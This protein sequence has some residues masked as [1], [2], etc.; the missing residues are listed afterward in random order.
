[1][2]RLLVALLTAGVAVYALVD[3]VRARADQVQRLPRLIWALLVMTLPLFGGLAYLF[4]GR[5]DPDALQAPIG[6][7]GRLAPDDDPDFLATLDPH[8]PPGGT[9]DPSL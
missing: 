5:A 3:L 8:R 6:K 2:P 7:N 4:L 1:M 9:E